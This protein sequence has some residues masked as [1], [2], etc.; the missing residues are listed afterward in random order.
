MA[1][2]N[3]DP[4]P[5]A[6]PADLPPGPA[7]EA[8]DTAGAGARET[9]QLTVV[10]PD[11]ATEIVLDAP[12][13]LVPHSRVELVTDVDQVPELITAQVPD[14][15]AVAAADE[16]MSGSASAD[17]APDVMGA[18]PEPGSDTEPGTEGRWQW[19]CRRQLTRPIASATRHPTRTTRPQQTR[20][21]TRPR[22]PQQ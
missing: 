17:P 4:R 1:E 11:T 7:P 14:P 9:E 18:D 19:T 12:A 10:E 21:P 6:P 8:D 13:E 3:P 15:Q 16:G 2:N 5:S 22:R 20:H